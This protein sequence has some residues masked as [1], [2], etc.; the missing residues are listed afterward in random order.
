VAL[1]LRRSGDRVLFTV[2]VSPRSASS[3]I[4]GERDGALVVRVTAPPAEGKANSAVVRILAKALGLPPSVVVI[5]RGS[6][7]RTKVLSVPASSEA[8]LRSLRPR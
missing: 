4:D 5:V 8:S 3:R 7:V 2:R 6:T 1:A